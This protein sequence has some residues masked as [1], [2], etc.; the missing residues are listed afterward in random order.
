MTSSSQKK[1]QRVF[2]VKILL[3]AAERKPFQQKQKTFLVIKKFT[4]TNAGR[5]S[6]RCVDDENL[7]IFQPSLSKLNSNAIISRK[8]SRT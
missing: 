5:S 7:E 1:K 2:Y 6:Q 3:K 8:K 4:P